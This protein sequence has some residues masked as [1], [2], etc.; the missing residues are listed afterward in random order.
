MAILGSKSS[1]W[2]HSGKTLFINSSSTFSPSW[3]IAGTAPEYD[4]EFTISWVSY[5]VFE[6]ISQFNCN[7]GTANSV[8]QKGVRLCSCL[9]IP[10]L[11]E[12]LGLL[13]WH[14]NAPPELLVGV[15]E[16]GRRSLEHGHLS[17]Q[18]EIFNQQVLTG[19]EQSKESTNPKQ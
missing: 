11:S 7:G 13:V 9:D 17:T 6:N 14:S 2:L 8:P 5:R 18:S 10:A 12:A 4:H 15:G 3:L 19:A 16:P 1:G